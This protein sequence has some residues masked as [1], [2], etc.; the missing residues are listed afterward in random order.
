MLYVASKLNQTGDP[1]GHANQ[2]GDSIN[3]LSA[4]QYKIVNV[5]HDFLWNTNIPSL[6][7]V[8]S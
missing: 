8:K 6:I 3:I 2:F 5:F 7:K 1:L 4:R